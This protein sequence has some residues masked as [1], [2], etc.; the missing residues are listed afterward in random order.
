[1]T[2][3]SVMNLIRY[4]IFMKKYFRN[5]LFCHIVCVDYFFART[6]MLDVEGDVAYAM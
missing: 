1:M 4:K 6:T 3:N 2:R 5:E